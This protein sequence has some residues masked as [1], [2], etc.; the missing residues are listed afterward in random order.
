MSMTL[1][2]TCVFIYNPA[3]THWSSHRTGWILTNGS[4]MAN[5]VERAI[6]ASHSS[7]FAYMGGTIILYILVKCWDPPLTAAISAAVTTYTVD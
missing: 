4:P 2:P 7:L 3:Y 6:K 5:K 1:L